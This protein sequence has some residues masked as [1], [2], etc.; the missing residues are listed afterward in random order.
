[1]THQEIRSKFNTH[2]NSDRDRVLMYLF[3]HRGASAK[4]LRFVF[5]RTRY[6]SDRVRDTTQYLKRRAK[7]VGSDL[8]DHL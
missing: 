6:S 3:E 4:E 2:E 7:E 5:G 1:M 8:F